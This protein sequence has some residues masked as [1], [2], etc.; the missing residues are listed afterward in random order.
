MTPE[1]LKAIEE[2]VEKAYG[3]SLS[4]LRKCVEEIKRLRAENGLWSENISILEDQVKH[5]KGLHDQLREALEEVCNN[6]G[7]PQPSYPA[8]FA[9]AYKIAREALSGSSEPH[10]WTKIIRNEEE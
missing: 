1:E 2:A 10:E 3:Y 5:W 7:V 6:L 4:D 9:Y 8:P